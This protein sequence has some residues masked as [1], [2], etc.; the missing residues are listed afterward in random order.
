MILYGALYFMT[1]NYWLF[2]MMSFFIRILQG[3][4]RSVYGI[5]NYAYLNIFWRDSFHKKFSI[6]ETTSA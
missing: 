1:D 6:M 3:M 4:S 2:L 5:V